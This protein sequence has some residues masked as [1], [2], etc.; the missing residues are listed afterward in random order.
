MRDTQVGHHS[1][2]GVFWWNGDQWLPAWSPDR[3]WWFDGSTWV[4]APRPK[5]L[6]RLDTATAVVWGVV[7]LAAMVLSADLAG[8]PNTA[9]VWVAWALGAIV[10]VA[11]LGL[12]VTGF[13]TSRGPKATDRF[14]VGIAYVSML[15]IA[16]Y[17]VAMIATNDPNA[18]T[19]AG[20]GLVVIGIPS[21]VGIA[22]LQ[23]LGA[24]VRLAKS[25]LGTRGA[26]SLPSRS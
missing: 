7:A 1:E 15:W 6:T 25:W 23:G 14:L 17:I 12:P 10:I 11:I 8:H 20:A 4:A 5:L 3:R 21:A 9:P 24:L 26:R 18:D 16:V 13:L 2:D 19:E 22:I